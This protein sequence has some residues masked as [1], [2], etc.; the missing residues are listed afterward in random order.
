MREAAV[1]VH[2]D[3]KTGKDCLV[4]FVSPPNVD[5][6]A[7][8]LTFRRKYPLY[9]VP[10]LFQGVESI[11]RLRSGQARSRSIIP[12]AILQLFCDRHMEAWGIDLY[13]PGCKHESL[14]I[15]QTDHAAFDAQVAGCLS[16]M[17]HVEV[18]S[19]LKHAVSQYFGSTSKPWGASF[20]ACVAAADTPG[21]QSLTGVLL[22][23]LV[24]KSSKTRTIWAFIC[25][26]T[27]ELGRSTWQQQ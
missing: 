17:S 7:L 26:A 2:P 11:P 19:V 10:T 12:G 27:M 15:L 3:E 1:V 18:P 8:D 23:L 21:A 9:M 24:K 25:P 16:S 22:V 5:M 20:W 4:A 13:T 14:Q 6:Q